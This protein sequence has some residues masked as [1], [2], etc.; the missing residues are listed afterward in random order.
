M[1][2]IKKLLKDEG[3]AII[4]DYFLIKKDETPNSDACHKL[5][6][7]LKFI[8]ENN[9]KIKYQEDITLNVLPTLDI[10]MGLYD[11]YFK[12]L[13]DYAIY[14]LTVKYKKLWKILN[15]FIK[16]KIKRVFGHIDLIRREAFIEY[17]KYKIFLIK[18]I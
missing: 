2:N 12:I 8:S 15:F 13:T 6:D 4:T 11:K 14:N 9:F 10:S 18:K 7:F 16:N 17:K 5:D 3:Y 1:K